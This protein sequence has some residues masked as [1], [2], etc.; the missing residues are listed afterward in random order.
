MRTEFHRLHAWICYYVDPRPLIRAMSW[1]S[2]PGDVARHICS[3]LHESHLVQLR[4][5]RRREAALVA[6][7]LHLLVLPRAAVF[8]ILSLLETADWFRMR[9]LNKSWLRFLRRFPGITYILT[10]SG[11]LLAVQ[12]AWLHGGGRCELVSFC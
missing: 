9:R 1:D 5:T 10:Q 6:R 3:Y 11:F 4:G 2:L 12:L 7:T 8:S